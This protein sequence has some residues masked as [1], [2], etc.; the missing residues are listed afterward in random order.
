M[1][2]L[3]VPYREVLN[4]RYLQDTRG[5]ELDII[6]D[7][8]DA[9]TRVLTAMEQAGAIQYRI[10]EGYVIMHRVHQRTA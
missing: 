9:L 1:R 2:R 4:K 8:V 5:I 3:P 10:V 7:A 6:S